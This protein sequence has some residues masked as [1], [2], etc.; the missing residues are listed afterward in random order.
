[1]TKGIIERTD[2]FGLVRPAVDAHTLGISS[3]AEVLADCGYASVIADAG[4]CAA[5]ARPEDP[6]HLAAIERWLREHRIACLG[7][8]YRLGPAEGADCFARLVHRLKVRRLLADQGGPLKRLFFAGLPDTCA[9]VKAQVRELS[10]I[11]IGD[12]TPAETLRILGVPPSALP[13]EVAEGAAYDETRLAFGRDLIRKGDYQAIE[14]VDRSGYTGFG[15]QQDTV[16]ARVRHG[17]E[18]G[19]PPLMRAHVGPYLDDRKEAVALFMDW[20]RRLAASRLLDVLSIGSSQLTQERFGEDWGDRPNGGGVPLNSPSE[21]AAV[22][23]AARPMLVRAYAGTRNIP[24]LARIHEETIHIA[25]HAL[26]LWWFCR[27][28][29]RGPYSVRENLEQHVETLRYIATTG[30]PFEPNLPHHFA[31]RG[32]DDVT[33]V[34]SAVLAARLAKSL[35]IRHLVLQ[36]MLNTP[37]STWGVQDLAK[38]RATLQL[39][40]ELED[41][42]FS[43]LLQPR[44]GLDY[45]SPDLIKAKAQIAAVTALM[46]DIEPDCATSPQIIHVVSYSE[47]SHLADPAV[48]DESIRITRCAL[49]E[50]R[51]L[52]RKGQV[53]DMTSHS[54]VVSRTAELLRESRIALDAIESR[55]PDVY[56]AEGLYQAFVRGFLAVPYLWECREEFQ[57]ATRWQTRLVRGSVKVVDDHGLPIPTEERVKNLV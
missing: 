50:Y 52:R 54:E 1:M 34:V 4:V 20:T 33:Y 41:A 17:I 3:V 53:D 49:D 35:G 29:G 24:A 10:G 9:R 15:T 51:R 11:F 22:W 31:F 48:V 16:V 2:V 37:K 45:F 7:F 12:E 55:I 39:V 30:K 21:L 6:A 26:S 27:I 38:C 25:W 13:R 56:S 46:D 19:L 32:A 40:R 5:F 18:H 8:S 44:G 42:R 43:V 14:A 28:D 23:D 47:A 36:L 57:R